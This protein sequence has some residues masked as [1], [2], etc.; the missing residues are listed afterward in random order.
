MANYWK[1]DPKTGKWVQDEELTQISKKNTPKA[2]ASAST[3]KSLEQ[4]ISDWENYVQNRSATLAA[5]DI[6]NAFTA[7][8]V[9][10]AYT[11]NNIYKPGGSDALLSDRGL[12]A[13]KQL[14]QQLPQYIKGLQSGTPVGM[15]E[16]D[17]L[18]LKLATSDLWKY[19]QTQENL[20]KARTGG[21]DTI[22]MTGM[23]RAQKQE[24]MR[25]DTLY[26]Y[27]LAP[28]K[29][30]A[31]VPEDSDIKREGVDTYQDL[32]AK[33]QSYSK[34]QVKADLKTLDAR[35]NALYANPSMQFDAKSNAKFDEA[36]A[37][38]SEYYGTDMSVM[39]KDFGKDWSKQMLAKYDADT[40]S[41]RG[42][43][44]N[45]DDYAEYD[46]S[47]A[48]N[49]EREAESTESKLKAWQQDTN[50]AVAEVKSMPEYGLFKNYV[51]EVEY[52]SPDM[53]LLEGNGEYITESGETIYADEYR[54]NTVDAF[55]A[56]FVDAG[57]DQNKLGQLDFALEM[58]PELNNYNIEALPYMDDDQRGAFFALWNSGRRD[59]AKQL[60]K[61]LDFGL[62]AK[63]VDTETKQLEADLAAANFWEKALYTAGTVPQNLINEAVG[64]TQMLAGI[65]NPKGLEDAHEFSAVYDQGRETQ[66]T[67][68]K[69]GQGIAEKHPGWTIPGTNM[70][71]LQMGYNAGTS[72]LD[73]LANRALFGWMGPKAPA[74]AMGSGAFATEYSQD[75]NYLDSLVAGGIEAGTEFIPFSILADNAIKPSVKVALNMLAEGF[76]E[77]TADTLN[78][79]YDIFK[80]GDAGDVKARWDELI[81][82]GYTPKEATGQLVKEYGLQIFES[83]LTGTMSGGTEAVTAVIDHVADSRRGNRLRTN[84]A[85][86]DLYELAGT[87]PIT[88]ASKRI[89]ERRKA[90]IEEGKKR[91]AE[92]ERAESEEAARDEKRSGD[93]AKLKEEAEFAEAE[94]RASE[95]ERAE[96]EE[97]ARD[98]KRDA[99][100]A[101][102]KAKAEAGERA[103]EIERAEA[104]EAERDAKRAASVE[105]L[106]EDARDTEMTERDRME[107]SEEGKAEAETDDA[108]VT[109]EDAEAMVKD[110]EKTARDRAEA[111]EGAKGE[112][113]DSPTIDAAAITK[114][115]AEAYK[116][117]AETEQREAERQKRKAE[118]K[119]EREKHRN[120]VRNAEIGF[121]FRD[122]MNNLDA[123]AKEVVAKTFS[124]SFVETALKESGYEGD[125]ITAAHNIVKFITGDNSK[126]VVKQL[127]SDSIVRDVALT[128]MGAADVERSM[129]YEKADGIAQ[130]AS[131]GYV[132]PVAAAADEEDKA[133]AFDEGIDDITDEDLD[134]EIADTPEST[135]DGKAV[136]IEGVESVAED[137]TVT[138]KVTDAD[139]NVSVVSESDITFG[140]DDADVAN[141]A[142]NAKSLGKNADTMIRMYQ[143]GQDYAKYSAQ[144]KQAV[145][146]GK[147]GRNLSNTT[148]DG[149]T[150]SELNGAQIEAAYTIGQSMRTNTAAPTRVNAKGISVGNVDMSGIREIALNGKQLA[151]VDAAKR[152]SR[153]VGFN[154]RFVNGLTNESGGRVHT[155]NGMWDPNTLTL[156]VDINA[157]SFSAGDASVAMMHTVGH[158]LTHYIRQFSDA[159]LWGEYQRFVMD[160]LS[161]KMGNA[162]LD[163]RISQLMEEQPDLTYEQAEE[164]IVAEASVEALRNITNADIQQLAA[165]NPGLFNKVKQ[166]IRKWIKRVKAEI[167]A[168]Y[169]GSDIGGND[170]AQD[171]MDVLDEMSSRWNELLINAA[172]NRYDIATGKADTVAEAMIAEATDGAVDTDGRPMYSLK[173]MKEDKTEYRRMLIQHGNMT[174]AEVDELFK[175]IDTLMDEV[176]KHRGILDFG[177]NI[178]SDK[179]S[180]TP[181]KPNSDPLY[182]VSVDFSTLCRKRLLQQACQER[183]E[184]EMGRAVTKA[185]RVAIREQLI[186]LQQ[187]GKQIEVA[188][189][190]CYV[191]SARLKSPAQIQKFMETRQQVIHDYFAR[192]NDAVKKQMKE[193]EAAYRAEKG[194]G[195]APLKNLPGNVRKQV[196]DAKNAPI[197]NYKLSAEEQRTADKAMSMSVADFTTAE[198]LWALK[199]EDPVLF[200]IYTSYIRN[201]TKSKGL[202][203]DT[204]WKAGDSKAISDELIAKMNA[205][206]G[207]RSQSWSDFQTYHMLD[208]I[209][210]IIELSTRNAKMQT[211][212]KVPDFVKLMGETGVMINMSLIPKA[213]FYGT[214]EYDGVEGIVPEEAFA[215]RDRYPETAGTICI[216]IDD[217][218]IEMLLDSDDI[219][220]VIPYH[221][222]GMDAATRKKMRIPTWTDY[223]KQQNER[224]IRNDAGTAPKF[225]EWFD[226]KKAVRDAEKANASPAGQAAIAEGDVMYGAKIAMQNAAQKYKDLCAERGLAPKFQKFADNDGYW[227]LLIDRKMINQKT[228][229]IIEQKAVKPVFKKDTLIEI[230]R[231]EVAR[232]KQNNADFEA[233]VDAVVEA[234]RNGTL[235]KIAKSEKVQ[236]QVKAHEDWMTVQAAIGTQERVEGRVMMQAKSG[237]QKYDYSKPFAEQIADY[238]AGLIPK[239][240]SLRVG[241]TPEVFRKI[242][243]LSLPMTINQT[244]IDYALNGS[245]DADHHLGEKLLAKLPEALE[246]PLAIITSKSKN[247]SSLVAVLAIRHNG[248]Q[249]ITPVVIDGFGTENTIQIDSN[250]VTSAYGKKYSITKVL[251]G[252][253][254]AEA[255]G[256]FSVYYIDNKKTTDLFRVAKVP[257]PKMPVTADGF[258][259]SIHEPG[260]PVKAKFESQT[261][262]Q[263]FERWFKD[264]KIVNP[265]GSPKV[266]FHQTNADFS[267]FDVGRNGA[268][269]L[270]S[271]MPSGIY[272]KDFPDTIKLG[273]DYKHSKQMDLYAAIKNPLVLVD[274]SAANSFWRKHVPGYSKMQQELDELNGRYGA[275]H[276]K[277]EALWFDEDDTVSEKAMEESDRILDEWTEAENAKRREMHVAIDNYLASSQYDGIILEQDQGTGGT[278]KT[279]VALKNTQVKSASENIGTFDPD[280]PDIR[281]QKRD[282]SSLSDSELLVRAL[283]TDLTPVEREHLERYKKKVD[284]RA[285]DQQ[286]LEKLH[287]RIVELRNA[288]Y[289]TRTSEELRAAE[290]NVKTLRNRID[291]KDAEL[292]KIESANMIREIVRRNREEARK[293]AYALA[294]ERA[295]ER[296]RKAVEEVRKVGERKVARL[297]DSQMK[298]KY[299]KQILD[300]VK[301]LHTWVVSPTN[302]GSVPEFLREPLAEFIDSIDFRSSKALAAEKALES[303]AAEEWLKLA[304]QRRDKAKERY[305][306]AV[307]KYESAVKTGDEELIKKAKQERNQA[308]SIYEM[309]ASA[310]ERG[311]E[312]S[313][314][315]YTAQDKKF[316]EALDKVRE[317]VSRLN[318]QYA[319]LEEGKEAFSGFVDLT[320]D[321]AVQFDKL[322]RGIK[323]T[324]KKGGDMTD[325]PFNRMTGQQ[326]KDLAQMFAILK[327]SISKM[328]RTL[329]NVRYESTKAMAIDEINDADDMTARRRMNQAVETFNSTFNWKNATPF[330]VFQRLGGSGKAVF[331]GLQDGWDKMAFNVAMIE[332]F[333]NGAFTNQ[334]SRAWSREVTEVKLDSDKTI[335]MTVA[336]KMSLYCHTKREQSRG[337]LMGGGIRVSDIAGVRGG[338]IVQAED[339]V[340][341]E[342]DI[343]RIVDSLTDRQR[344]VADKLQSFMNDQCAKWGNEISMKRF[345]F[346]QMTERNYFPIKTDANNRRSIDESKEG[347]NSMFR[348]LNLA[349]LKPITPGADNAII[350]E[351]IFNVFADHASD[352]AKYNALALPILDFIKWYNYVERIDIVDADGK[353]TG[354]HETRSVQKALERAYGK[355][356][357]SYLT[358]FIRDLNAEHDGGRND[359]VINRL[360]NRS[361]IASVGANLRV[362]ALQITSIPRAAFAINPRY[363]VQ[364]LA[365]LNSLNPV[366]AIRGTEAQQ[367]IGILKWKNLGFFSTDF[368]RSTREMIKGDRGALA[369]LRELSMKP[370]EWGDNWVSN[371]IYEAVRAE[372]RDNHSGIKPGTEQYDRMV[373]KR[374]R[375]IVYKTQVVD[376]TMT[377]S[378]LMR[379]KGVMAMFT[380]FMSEPTITVNMINEGIQDAIRRRRGGKLDE[381]DFTP[382]TK[383]FRAFSVLI[384]GGILQAFI[385][386]LP[387]AFRDDDEYE[388]FG[389]KYLDAFWQN[390]IDSV[391]VFSM[392][393]LLSEATDA[394]EAM[395]KGKDYKPSS[396]AAQVL[397]SLVDSVNAVREYT[398]GKRTF[399][400]VIYNTLKAFS[401]GFGIGAYNG[402]RDLISIYNTCIANGANLPKLQYYS[403][404]EEKAAQALYDAAVA[405]DTERFDELVGRTLLYGISAEDLENE[406]NKIISDDYVAGEVSLAEAKRMLKMYGGK[407]AYQAQQVLDK[408]DY[409]IESG[410]K[411]NDLEDEYVAGEVSKADARSALTKYGDM[412]AK[413][414]DAKILTWDY[415]KAT[416]RKYSAISNDYIRG[417]IKRSEIKRAMVQYGGKD[418]GSAETAILHLDYQIKTERPWSSLMDDYHRG[419]FTSAQVKKFLMDYDQK[420]ADEAEDILDKY[421]WAKANGGSTEGYS[422]YIS[423]HEAIDR[424][425]GLDAAVEALVAKYTARGETRKEVLSS[426]R[427]SITSKYK[428][429]YLA[430]SAAEQA[431]MREQLLDVYVQLGGNYNT[432]YKNMTKT[433]F[434]N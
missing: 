106:K 388:T 268:G 173:T 235:S 54:R 63:R 134:I 228:G 129:Y 117:R 10:D 261:E 98:A 162:A 371:I 17:E 355:D 278:V 423:V 175:A 170:L 160:H 363:L 313:S 293:A 180:F 127:E 177:E 141:V 428:P 193:A 192:K 296:Q 140:Q 373:N 75:Q 79:L 289:D 153:A 279:Y 61:N 280:N 389:E 308:K 30:G 301:K 427:S 45:Y 168:A 330:M 41:L 130:K 78:I 40:E 332:E 199:R 312:A 299:R 377:R 383:L 422:K 201:A 251:K 109:K 154:V 74:I 421:D 329:A 328:N 368:S 187:E 13:Y 380:S 188:C 257:M 149:R 359:H 72:A 352:M 387:D 306:K 307:A 274:R 226:Y 234:G 210:A 1:K 104:E 318:E 269:Y 18:A 252:A 167:K 411:F 47:I 126:G 232:F 35:F 4:D 209:A 334:E 155:A 80:K 166:F 276:A 366:N 185:E 271:E 267:A 148:S 372:M 385:A 399:T 179:R 108:A 204:P 133:D 123:G 111:A 43:V 253:L 374:V 87:M 331:E 236:K 221:K 290:T 248:K 245:K 382:G 247:A 356:A 178:D 342:G 322:V 128:F 231:D 211:Y 282:Y 333:K 408:L 60:L 85:E 14:N 254:D 305:D 82:M 44:G 113:A 416:G 420:D 191:E 264:S 34:K 266:L 119:A 262:T 237:T 327:T 115:Y 161:G 9:A 20:L 27:D 183:L 425:S 208:Y 410:S 397:T 391:N 184:A 22:D 295:D 68:G 101:A 345:G 132:K 402:T 50:S 239:N 430:S 131:K 325:I 143:R 171:M 15:T 390:A 66:T 357:K 62:Q 378:E 23:P 91:A 97:S 286:E 174:S 341:T 336:Q 324:L 156:T 348:L 49:A 70:N 176:E 197:T 150:F 152:L 25:M 12:Y 240:D 164:E 206:N 358:T 426:I 110:M 122:V 429:I 65:F 304:T 284:A 124:R 424:G 11:A 125:Y 194:I 394:L 326:L 256:T 381:N 403:D 151:A 433:W 147:R 275:E 386:S 338:N 205:E 172:K 116:K 39:P 238:K 292:K 396:L 316:T 354:K 227:K 114:D 7:A 105:A 181:V 260:S 38:L 86:A 107:R 93:V 31:A 182:Q 220:Y 83:T 317:A 222:S 413:E 298:E 137:G 218:Q 64:A 52:L 56:A 273:P 229:E 94:E 189:A 165:N 258:V 415:E 250:A 48:N 255:N 406:Y 432:Y 88:E 186:K 163:D 243:L 225:S 53:G 55:L 370:A 263:Q 203:G 219:D 19:S 339:Y 230:C 21:I 99:D 303:G 309:E 242:G 321:Y 202:E 224:P 343:A 335:Q 244:H 92:V 277:W 136:T 407:T 362:Y 367:K 283:E 135:V 320:G 287:S 400:N 33:Q 294:R 281:Y 84:E 51:P 384:V 364:G 314:M 146:Y 431:R 37:R 214:L 353:P 405:G 310:V 212:T 412:T 196:R 59:E 361:K 376:S 288:G 401:Y 3:T 159:S 77:G 95:V 350:I 302:K 73:S 409:Q 89:I 337:H 216:G 67:R 100:V 392:V 291:R 213:K 90:E 233:A 102:L 375:E 223:E 112:K 217:K 393:P 259:H 349:S 42:V 369:R 28:G 365:N 144:F 249:V 145:E 200:D 24:L 71:L 169:A 270:D 190:L 300:D 57:N 157:G 297:K 121:V 379:S 346:E 417:E 2:S 404:N 26:G 398:Q 32:H 6:P 36:A 315:E 198:S 285:K 158:E 76:G 139:G 81:T 414:A 195:D 344:E 241:A 319:G 265:D 311:I 434:D 340:L 395:I 120:R 8:K 419:K 103:S 272:M 58:M 96:G 142:E 118:R 46:Q 351:D 360:V 69:I 246:E 207:L 323:E 29:L 418:E 215:L 347:S 138:Y 16:E 5:Q